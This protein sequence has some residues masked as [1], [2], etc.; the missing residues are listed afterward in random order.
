MGTSLQKI[1][2]LLSVAAMVIFTASN[3]VQSE[4]IYIAQ[5][6]QGA[7]TGADATNAHAAAWLNTAGNWGAGAGKISAGDTVRLVGTFTPP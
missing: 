6:A 5:T 4:S 7:N 1:S 3:V 2:R